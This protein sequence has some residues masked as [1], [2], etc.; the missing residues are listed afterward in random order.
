MVNV[1]PVAVGLATAVA[2]DAV[3]AIGIDRLRQSS[4][5]NKKQSVEDFIVII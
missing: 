1:P 2:A 3:V 4:Q 5:V